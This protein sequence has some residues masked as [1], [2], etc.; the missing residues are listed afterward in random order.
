[1]EAL[2]GFVLAGGSGKR[3]MPLTMK[4]PK[5]FLQVAGRQ[6]LEYSVELLE[7]AGVDEIVVIAPPGRSGLARVGRSA[8]VVEQRGQDVAGAL[9][10][11]LEEARARRAREALVA[12]TGF[13]ARPP[14]LARAVLEHYT[15]SGSPIV[16]A[17]APV[18]T[19]LETYGFAELDY[20][21]RVTSFMAPRSPSKVWLGGRGYVFAG[22][23]ALDVGRLEDLASAPFE[24]SMSR[25]A[26]RGLVGGF[27]WPERWVEVGYP[28]D[29]LELLKVVLAE[30]GTSVSGGASVGASARVGRGVV[31]DEGAVV[32]DGAVIVGPA[33][34]G[35]GARVLSGAVIKPYTSVEEGA[36]VGEGAVVSNS[37]VMAGARVGA[38]SEVRSSIVGEGA[39][40]EPGAHLVEGAPSM[41]P[42]RL[43]WAKE[44]LGEGLRLGA[45]VAPGM[46]V[47][48]CSYIGRGQVVEP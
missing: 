44:Y 4:T 38:L 18:A 29:L 3:L 7:E 11:A 36:E 1:M 30:G 23:M 14:T 31:I 32:E 45:V 28:W 9:R 43:A 40:V 27:V 25:A 16:I 13:V 34:I 22:V 26:A 19:G 6:L 42:E 17:L 20:T 15:T 8:H 37:V 33:Y 5:P 41:L 46:T 47:R 24:E 39:V 2:I 21:G 12:Y 48:C 10:T 35:R